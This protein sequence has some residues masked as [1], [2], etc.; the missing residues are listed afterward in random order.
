MAVTRGYPKTR[1]DIIDQTQIP[2][3]PVEY[4]YDTTAIIMSAFTS[5]KGP[6]NWQMIT[7]LTDFT[8]TYGGINF[9]RHGQQQLMIAEILRKGGYVF[10]KRMVS[11]NATLANVTIHARV[12]ESDGISYVYTYA[13]SEANCGYV[14][15]AAEGGYGS[16]NFDDTSILDFPLFT[17]TAKGRGDCTLFFRLVPEYSG[18]RATTCIRYSLEIYE[19][20]TLLETVICSLNPAYSIDDVSQNIQNKVNSRSTQ[21]SCVMF[22]DGIYGLVRKLAETA[23]VADASMTVSELINQDFINGKTRRGSSSLG[24]I[25]TARASDDSTD[26][27][28]ANMPADLTSIYQLDTANGIPLVNGTSGTLGANP[29]EQPDELTQ[30]L[31]GA[32]GKNQDSEQFDPIIYDLDS[33]KPDAIFD[34]AYPMAV[35]NAIIDVCDWRGDIMFFAD[36]GMNLT[37]LNSIVEYASEIYRSRYCAVYHNHFNIINP[38]TKK[39]IHVTMP[40]LLAQRFV[41][42]MDNGVGRPFAGIANDLT[43]PEIIMGSLNF[44]PIVVPGM[45]QKQTLADNC[46]NYINYYDGVPVM[47]TMYVTYDEYTQLSFLHNMLSIQQVIKAIRSHCPKVRYTF[48]D[49]DDLEEY[50]ED[51]R[52][53]LNF[54]QSNFRSIDI[55]YMADEKYELNN[56][57]YATITV[58][59]HNFIQEEYF[60]IYAIN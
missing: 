7:D 35:K 56:I 20:N 18:S 43:F 1:F 25:I 30:L 29:M 11:S 6:E 50:I 45:D 37:T 24:N 5:D 54:F 10:G 13:T 15:Q 41:K 8:N 14:G 16:Y 47:E 57:F 46:I 4:T 17:I 36:L 9:E 60:K 39:S 53:V 38:Y 40:Y 58:R 33:I 2:A 44:Q 42:H 3:L 52:T 48:L 28:I 31:L 26:E 21:V 23:E 32:W 27:W 55:Q 12:V 59:F 19:D 22:E 49:G 34:S 51:A